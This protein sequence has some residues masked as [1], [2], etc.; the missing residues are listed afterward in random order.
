MF[1]SKCFYLFWQKW[2]VGGTCWYWWTW[3]V[4]E[5]VRDHWSQISKRWLLGIP[6]PRKLL[7]LPWHFTGQYWRRWTARWFL[8]HC[9]LLAGGDTRWWG[10]F[11]CG[12]HWWPIRALPRRDIGERQPDGQMHRHKHIR[13]GFSWAVDD[14]G[15]GGGWIAG[16]EWN[17]KRPLS[18]LCLQCCDQI[19]SGKQRVEM[20]KRVAGWRRLDVESR[21]DG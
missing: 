3:K 8:C 13:C 7:C 16:L 5:D 1:N 14:E 19:S 20:G 12:S 11:C 18:S 17:W 10:L 4:G 9:E 21:S 15:W 2:L 6:S